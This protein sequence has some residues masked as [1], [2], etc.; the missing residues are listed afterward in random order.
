MFDAVDI[1]LVVS[2]FGLII[3]KFPGRAS[4]KPGILIKFRS[5][6]FNSVYLDHMKK[7][8]ISPAGGAP[9]LIVG[10]LFESN[11]LAHINIFSYIP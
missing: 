10:H 2:K 9:R 4:V 8:N 1:I 3:S 5:L 7:A 11:I 6:Q